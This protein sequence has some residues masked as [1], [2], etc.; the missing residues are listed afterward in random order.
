MFCKSFLNLSQKLK[1]QGFVSATGLHPLVCKT[2][3]AC[4]AML[5][6]A[7]STQP[8]DVPYAETGVESTN[9]IREYG[10]KPADLSQTIQLPDHFLIIAVCIFANNLC[11]LHYKISG[12]NTACSFNYSCITF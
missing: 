4:F 6:P 11:L 12:I 3:K 5:S 9:R 10:S 8:A 7:L 2:A 1:P